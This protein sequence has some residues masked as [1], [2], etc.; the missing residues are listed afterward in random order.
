MLFA[1]TCSLLLQCVS[2]V[3]TRLVGRATYALTTRIRTNMA[4]DHAFLVPK[5]RLPLQA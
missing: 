4:Q 5:A 3:G 1:G 2:Q